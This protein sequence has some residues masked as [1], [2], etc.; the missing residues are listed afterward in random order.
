M[1]RQIVR[2]MAEGDLRALAVGASSVS[3]ETAQR[4]H[5]V[6]IA[7]QGEVYV[8]ARSSLVAAEEGAIDKLKALFERRTD[9]CSRRCKGRPRS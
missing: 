6:L 1:E 9:V 8:L 5:Q 2:I 4:V 7:E 3:G